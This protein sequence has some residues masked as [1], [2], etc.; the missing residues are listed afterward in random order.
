MLADHIELRQEIVPWRMQERKEPMSGC[1]HT[2]GRK[3][4]GGSSL[5]QCSQ[6]W[7]HARLSRH[8]LASVVASGKKDESGVKAPMHRDR[9]TGLGHQL[10]KGGAEL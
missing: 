6:G 5:S 3:A 7:G 10:G 4:P 2:V 9:E 1:Q 8:Y